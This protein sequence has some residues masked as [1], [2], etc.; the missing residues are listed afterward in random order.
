MDDIFHEEEIS[1]FKDF[2][3]SIIYNDGDRQFLSDGFLFRG[4]SD[5]NYKLRPTILRNDDDS[6][7]FKQLSDE[8]GRLL[9]FYTIANNNGLIVPN[10]NEFQKMYLAKSIDI[11]SFIK[12]TKDKYWLTRELWELAALGQH[13]GLKTRLLD[14]TTDINVAL[15][16]ATV[17]VL[18]KISS[19]EV[20]ADKFSLWCIN[21]KNLQEYNMLLNMDALPVS[22]TDCIC[23]LEFIIPAYANNPNIN[24]Q[25]GVLSLWK[26][27]ICCR[28][29]LKENKSISRKL[30]YTKN[31]NSALDEQLKNFFENPTHCKAYKAYLDFLKGQRN[32]DMVEKRK[33]IICRY[34]FSKD[35]I[36]DIFSTI[37][38]LGYNAAKLFPGYRGIVKSITERDYFEK[39]SDMHAQGKHINH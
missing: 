9:A 11:V 8:F 25:Q 38:R 3:D 22:K 5:S 10:I 32:P 17:N 4:E 16:F 15:Y 14:W 33:Y 29:D 13:Y 28:S 26:E 34:T 1:N 31:N 6:I 21:S 37:D 24:A 36:F 12:A 27:K 23:P 18:K 19:K 39:I 2:Y 30:I 20:V 35:L 7:L